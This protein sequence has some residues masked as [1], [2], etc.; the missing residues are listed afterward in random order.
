MSLARLGLVVLALLTLGPVATS[1]K[2]DDPQDATRSR[3]SVTWTD[4]A[5]F[6]ELRF[7]HQF[8]Q[9]KPEVW[10]GEF[11]KTLV[12]SAD[13][14]LPSGQHLSI[15][16]T[17]V[18]LAGDFEPWHGPFLDDVRIVK[19]IYPPRMSLSFTLTDSEGKVLESG[20]R[21]LRDLAFLNRGT[22]VHASEPYRYEK[23]MLRDW[24]RREF[25]EDKS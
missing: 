12:N 17:D 19:S 18:K 24:V 10:L 25:G 15:T 4:P 23:R 3:V 7:G 6:D 21:E 14:V 9:P 5:E 13:R 16:I 22:S 1:A 2:A 11:R 8:R 20:E